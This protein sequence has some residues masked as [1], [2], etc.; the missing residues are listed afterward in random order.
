MGLHIQGFHSDGIA[1]INFPQKFGFQDFGVEVCLFLRALGA[2][3]LVVYGLKASLK[4]DGFLVIKQISSSGS[5]GCNQRPIW[6][7]SIA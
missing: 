5:G 7:N 4:T 3:F 1:K 2:I 6:V